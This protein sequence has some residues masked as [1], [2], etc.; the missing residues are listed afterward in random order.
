ML[1]L[2][3]V[4]GE[5]RGLRRGHVPA[6]RQRDF[7]AQRHATLLGGETRLGVAGVADHV[8]ETLTVERTGRP[9]ERG[10]VHDQP[11]DF[12]IRKAQAHLA[13]LLID[14]R[15]GDELADDLLLEPQFMRLRRG[16]GMA[17]LATDLLEAVVVGLAELLDRNLGVADFGKARSPVAAENVAD[18][19]N[20]EGE[21]EEADDPAHDSFAER[22]GGGFAQTA[23]HG[24]GIVVGGGGG[25]SLLLV[26]DLVRKPVSSLGIVH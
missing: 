8:L 7:P 13:R 6:D 11:G 19:P 15:L 1:V 24:D 17:Q 26:H 9:A 25:R 23:E 2:E 10:I 16:D 21:D 3:A 22:G 20:A 5:R 12:R 14:R 18:A 4:D